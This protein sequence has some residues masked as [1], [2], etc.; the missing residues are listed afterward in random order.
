MTAAELTASFRKQTGKRQGEAF[1]E[2]GH[3]WVIDAD[4][5]QWPTDQARS[6]EGTARSIVAR[7][8]LASAGG[9]RR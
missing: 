7:P 8:H 9:L 3:W 4:G 1:Q 2:D 5:H 6:R